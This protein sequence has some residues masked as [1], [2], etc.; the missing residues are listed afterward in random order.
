M[1]PSRIGR[2]SPWSGA[3]VIT[4]VG[5]GP[6]EGLGSTVGVGSVEGV[7]SRD[8]LGSGVAVAS[9]VGVGC[10]S[11]RISTAYTVPPE[12]ER[13]TT[14]ARCPSGATASC[15]GTKSGRK[16]TTRRTDRSSV[17]HSIPDVSGQTVSMLPV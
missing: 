17:G 5:V 14:V 2:A 15:S 4:T 12:G 9:G 7:G 8:P 3:A 13:P 1:M 10:S 16:V 6:A 11:T